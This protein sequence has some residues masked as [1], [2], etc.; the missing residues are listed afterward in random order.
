MTT[1][2]DTENL[3]QLRLRLQVEILRAAT[4][5]NDHAIA[6]GM[7]NNSSGLVDIGQRVERQQAAIQGVACNIH[8]NRRVSR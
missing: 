8:P 6:G 5:K 4:A 3:P 2:L 1:L 7:V